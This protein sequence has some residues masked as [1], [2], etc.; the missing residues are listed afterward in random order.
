MDAR[1]LF[2]D[3]AARMGIELSGEQEDSFF[4][5]KD[6]LLEWNKKMN[7]TAITDDKDIVIKHFA[8]C[9]SILSCFSVPAG[10]SV[11]DVGT[12]AGFP[13]IPVKIAR[14]DLDMT[15]LDSLNKRITFLEEVKKSLGLEKIENIHM[16]AEEG[17]Q[18]R[19]YREKFDF[20]ISRAVANLAVLSEYCLPF[21]REGGVFISL[22]GPDVSDEI[23]GSLKAIKIFGGE[24]KDIIN[25]SIPN[26]DISHSLVIIEKIGKTPAQY[27]RKAGT[28]VKKPIK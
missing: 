14:G 23:S 6:L 22:K 2:R 19:R 17:G 28:A 11:I 10:A 4:K 24:V 12:G 8:D 26:S 3:T 15:L 27:P 9:L 7:L 5:Y 16:R 25:V 21:V 20:C 1:E 18:D 13:G